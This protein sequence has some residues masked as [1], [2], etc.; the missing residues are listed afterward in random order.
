MYF[1]AIFSVDLNTPNP[2]LLTSRIMLQFLLSLHTSGKDGAC[3]DG[4]ESLDGKRTVNK[5][6]EGLVQSRRRQLSTQILERVFKFRNAFPCQ[7]GDGNDRLAFKK[8]SFN[9]FLDLVPAKL[10]HFRIFH[11]VNPSQCNKTVRDLKK[12]ADVQMF[13]SLGHDSL[14]SGN[15]Q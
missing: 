11:Q 7:R 4:S 3:D 1:V 15:H 6:P 8:S 12:V 5:H 13:A 10:D 2:D 9:Q 14:V